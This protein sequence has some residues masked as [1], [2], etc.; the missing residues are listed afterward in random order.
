MNRTDMYRYMLAAKLHTYVGKHE[1][2]L[3][4]LTAGIAA[5]PDLPHLYRHRGHFRVS[6]RDFDGA[7]ED[8]KAAVARLDGMPDEIEYYQA[9]LVPEMERTILGGESELLASPTPI[10]PENLERLKDVYKGTLK[11]STWYHYGLAHYLRGEFDEAA[12]K[13][14]TT[15]KFCVDDDM[16]VATVDWLFMSFRRA[17]RKDEAQALLDQTS[18]DMHI[19][20]P[21]YYR[22]MQMYKGAMTPEELLDLESADRRTLAT[23]GYGVGNW[24]LTEGDEAAAVRVFERILQKGDRFAFGTIAAETDLKR[25][26]AA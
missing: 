21:S 3:R 2:A 8:F 1:D 26:K 25:L 11:S 15:L 10:T 23:Q 18:L 24:Y 9:E 6:V 14:R 22:R 16:T 7:I 20:E 4:V 13:Y 5:H 19:N 17:G 12:D